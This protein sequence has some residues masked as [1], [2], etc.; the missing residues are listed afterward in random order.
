MDEPRVAM[1]A[2]ALRL[3]ATI[4]VRIQPCWLRCPASPVCYSVASS[5]CWKSDSTAS[6]V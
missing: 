3:V 6:Q 4:G 1:P 2:E 5:I